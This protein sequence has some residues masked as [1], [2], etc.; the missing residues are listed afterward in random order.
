MASYKDSINIIRPEILAPED[1]RLI[2]NTDECL[3]F[4]NK[5]RHY[6]SRSNIKGNKFV[7]CSLSNVKFID[8]GAIAIFTAIS[9]NHNLKKIGLRT[10]FPKDKSCQQFF[11][12]SGLLSRFF[13]SNG[14]RIKNKSNSSVMVFESGKGKLLVSDIKSMSNII[15]KSAKHLTKTDAY[16]LPINSMLKEICGNSIEWGK[17]SKQWLFGL[18]FEDDKIIFN[19]TDVGKGILKTLNIKFN[20]T[21]R[22]KLSSKSDLE[23][24]NGAFE[25][26]YNSNTHEINRNKGLPSIRYN[27]KSGNIK[28]LVVLTNN[29]ILHFENNSQSRTLSNNGSYLRGTYYQWEMDLECMNKIYNK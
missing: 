13:D 23:I 3:K 22:D 6:D 7:K 12:N 29:V 17:S 24:L 1:F 10:V 26:K 9:D 28:N 25:K 20:K 5:I 11:Y 14:N 2:E 4:F 8:Y 15:K 18:K 19:V 16:C 27:F 21:F